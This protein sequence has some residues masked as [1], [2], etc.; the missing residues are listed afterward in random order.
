MKLFVSFYVISALASAQVSIDSLKAFGSLD[1]SYYAT[2]EIN[3]KVLENV[4]WKE[5]S[6]KIT[7]GPF[8]SSFKTLSPQKRGFWFT[9]D[10]F[11]FNSFKAD[12]LK[13]FNAVKYDLKDKLKIYLPLKNEVDNLLT[14]NDDFI[15]NDVV[16]ESDS[17]FGKAAHFN[18][19]SSY[20]DLRSGKDDVF[21]EL[22][23][24]AWVKPTQIRDKHSIIG[25]GKVFSAKIVDG[26]LQFTTPSI[27]DHF[28]EH[29]KINEQEWS[30]VAF[31]YLPNNELNFFINGNLVSTIKSSG[32]NQTDH[33]LVVGTNLWGE[34]YQGFIRDLAIWQRPLSDDEIKQIFNSGILLESKTSSFLTMAILVMLGGTLIGFLIIKYIRTKSVNKGVNNTTL[35]TSLLK[36]N[37]AGIAIRLLGGFRVVN[38]DGADIT[39]KFPPKRRELI[40]CLLLFTLK[41]DGITSKKMGQLLWPSFSNA[42]VKN[43]RSTQVK[44]IRNILEELDGIEVIYSDKKW[45]VILNNS[46]KIDLFHLNE[47][48]PHIFT[49]HKIKYDYSSLK[50]ILAILNLGILLPNFDEEWID[51][52]KSKFDDFILEFL[53]PCL[54][55]EHIYSDIKLQVCDVIL[56]IDALHEEAVDFKVKLLM[57]QGKHMSAQKVS[58]QFYKL[59]EQFY[60][61]QY[62]KDI[63]N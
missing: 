52:F 6:G 9:P 46:S 31:V 48:L 16:F 28:S 62:S 45:R 36:V 47:R 63:L 39:H 27:K 24:A 40:I 38:K 18:G 4:N 33:S 55:D 42:Q 13:V 3:G 14:T 2:A 12:S 37:G 56:N 20:I 41:E 8:K 25:K 44:E 35:E 21:E 51:S 30:H 17:K 23:I 53:T 5:Y 7:T 11:D 61:Q 29:N 1:I 58:E 10:I 34:H 60:G 22:T 57:K 59:Y 50:E 43:N 54:S 15:Y 19:T 49:S 26:Y 32:I